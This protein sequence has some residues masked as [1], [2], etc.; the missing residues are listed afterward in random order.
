[1]ATKTF[2]ELKQLAIQIRDEKTNKQNTATRIGTQMLEHL[3]KLEQDYYDKTATDEELQARDEKLTELENTCGKIQSHILYPIN[4]GYYYAPFKIKQGTKYTIRV[5]RIND[6]NGT[7][8]FKTSS[9]EKASGLIDTLENLPF[10]E[11]ENVQ[12]F[13]ASSDANYIASYAANEG[14]QI[15]FTL[16]STYTNE[17]IENNKSKID[18]EINRAIENEN[19]IQT[20]ITEINNK[21][22]GQQ[23]RNAISNLVNPNNIVSSANWFLCDSMIPKNSEITIAK[24]ISLSAGT[25]TIGLWKY[26]NSQLELME[27][28][29]VTAIS[30]NETKDISELL[31]RTLDYNCFVAVTNTDSVT[32][33]LG[34]NTTSGNRLYFSKSDKIEIGSI[35][36]FT[37]T[38]T[39][40]GALSMRITYSMPIDNSPTDINNQGVL[41]VGATKRYKTIQEAVNIANDGNTIL[42]YPGIYDEQVQ[43]T[44]KTLHIIGINKYTC[45]LRDRSS[46]Y[47][48]PPIEIQSG[49]ITNMSIYETADMPT[50]G[51]ENIIIPGTSLNAK[52][53]AYCI[54]ADWNF[55][56]KSNNELI[57]DNCILKN[58]NRPCVGAGLHKNSSLK[59]RRCIMYSGISDEGKGRGAFY[60]H[61]AADG[62]EQQF[63]ELLNNVIECEDAIAM[64]LRGYEGGNMYVSAYSN[65][66]YSS[67]NGKQDS[68]VNQNFGTGLTLLPKSYGNNISVLNP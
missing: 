54:H 47:Y 4:T 51:L 7:V 11:M 63:L 34:T 52:N 17:A 66:V 26:E 31:N 8:Q 14:I 10:S 9:I 37:D 45:I 61:A 56:V 30:A 46:N 48:T 13:I 23:T 60:C 58:A 19:N 41:E 68:A 22:K 64:E 24:F 29:D 27:K 21:S 15:V 20:Q 65:I 57:I 5:R 39:A 3:D 62:E 55:N 25:S 18:S 53:M 33:C 12:S 16:D 44:S 38:N 28:F 35:A 32:G 67:I 36:N 1:M 49:S 40:S 2:E 43:A 42:I 6:V 59:V 50:E